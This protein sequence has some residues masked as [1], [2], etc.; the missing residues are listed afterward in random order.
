MCSL[1]SFLVVRCLRSWY[2]A[3]CVLVFI[4][5]YI[6]IYIYYA[7]I[8]MY[9]YIIICFFLFLSFSKFLQTVS[10]SHDCHND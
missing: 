5:I 10:C 3:T 6:Y 2:G 4:Y 7:Y 1:K 9:I 8:Y